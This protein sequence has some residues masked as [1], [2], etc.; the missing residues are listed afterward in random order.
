MNSVPARNVVTFKWYNLTCSCSAPVS[1]PMRELQKH[2]IYSVPHQN[3]HTALASYFFLKMSLNYDIY[4]KW[5]LVS[6]NFYR[7]W[8][9][10]RKYIFE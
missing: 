2:L 5:Y 9:N 4:Y 10:G 7:K 3:W 8:N 1:N 6:N